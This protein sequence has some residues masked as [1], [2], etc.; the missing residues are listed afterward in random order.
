M[1]MWSRGGKIAETVHGRHVSKP[2]A[3]RAPHVVRRT[4]PNPSHVKFSLLSAAVA[5]A[6]PRPRVPASPLLARVSEM[7]L[8]R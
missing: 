8:D 6:S 3:R 1:A 4:C 7:T 5:I 2:R